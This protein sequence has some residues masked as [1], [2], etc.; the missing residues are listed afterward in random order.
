MESLKVSRKINIIRKADRTEYRRM[1][2]KSGTDNPQS[3]RKIGASTDENGILRGL[4]FEEEKVYVSRLLG[5]D[6][7]NF[8][9]WNKATQNYWNGIS[10]N[11]EP[12][13]L[14]L[15]IGFHYADAATKKLATEMEEN[16]VIAKKG[17]TKKFFE[18]GSESDKYKLVAEGKATPLNIEHYVLWRYLLV[19]SKCANRLEWADNSANI[20]F[21]IYDEKEEVE[22]QALL[23]KQENEASITYLELIGKIEKAKSVVRL[24]GN[25]SF[26]EVDVMKY[27]VLNKLNTNIDELSEPFIALILD[28]VKTL[29]PFRLLE[30]AKDPML[31]SKAMVEAYLSYGVLRKPFGTNM[32]LYGDQP[33]GGSIDEVVN[34]FN[35]K[36]PEFVKV[37]NEIKLRYAQEK[38]VKTDAL[39]LSKQ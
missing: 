14:E 12:D 27:P 34:F 25:E 18:R 30:I 17:F 2:E 35:S 22:K 31:E 1:V 29:K 39:R 11:V 10:Y 38:K 24:F 26:E 37:I 4:S 7:N 21:V 23:K 15:E 36:E 32:V 19:Y 20:L 8:L 16:T 13:G 33:L 9:E 6:P 3:K 5:V 28:A